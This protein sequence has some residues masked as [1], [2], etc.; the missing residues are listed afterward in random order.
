MY[1]RLTYITYNLGAITFSGAD[2][3]RDISLPPGARLMNVTEINVRV[4]TTMAG[5]TPPRVN[6]GTAANPV[7]FASLNLGAT[8]AAANAIK[9]IRDFPGSKIKPYSAG[10]VDGLLNSIRVTGLIGVGGTP[11]GVADVSVTIGV[12]M[13]ASPVVPAVPYG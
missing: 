8:A 1:D 13:S 3:V 5:T 11:A 6:V 10:D 9:G 12:D 2:T 7:A 4:T